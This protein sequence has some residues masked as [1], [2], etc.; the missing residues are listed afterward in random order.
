MIKP[1]PE[2]KV[3]IK[4]VRF[5]LAFGGIF[6]GDLSLFQQLNKKPAFSQSIV[7]PDQVGFKY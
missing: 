1:K 2:W 6:L 3:R 5:G 7:P 4:C